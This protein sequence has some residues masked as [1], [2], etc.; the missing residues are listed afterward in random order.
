MSLLPDAWEMLMNSKTRPSVTQSNRATLRSNHNP[1]TTKLMKHT[2]LIKVSLTCL[3]LAVMCGVAQAQV[4]LLGNPGFEQ[5][6][7]GKMTN[8]DFVAPWAN[9]GVNYT[10]T[11]VEPTG[12]HSGTYRAFEM[13]GDDGAYQISPT[14]AALN[15][16]D[17]IVLAWWALG[18]TSGTTNGTGA[19]DPMQIVGIIRATNTSD[20]FAD[21]TSLIITSNGLSNLGWVQ[22]S[23]SYTATPADAGKFPGCFFNTGEVGTNTANVWAGYDDFIMYVLP[24]GSLPI[25]STP[26][27]SQTAPVGSNLTFTVTALNATG[28]RW[29]AGAPGSGVYTNLPNA[30]QY[31]GVTTT[32][33][34][35]T[36]VTTNNNLDIVVVVSNG[37]GSVTS[38]PPANLTVAA[39]IYQEN[40]N[41]PT[42]SDQPIAHVGWRNDI[43]GSFGG[44]DFARAGAGVTYPNMAVYSYCGAAIEAFYGTTATINGGPYF[45]GTVSNHMAFPGV[46]LAVAQNVSFKVDLNT[47]FLGPGTRSFICVQMNL[48]NWFVSTNELL[49]QPTG[50]TFITDAYK[51]NPIASAWNDLTVSGTGSDTVTLAPVIGT[52]ATNNMTGYITGIGIVCQHTAGST[53][54]FDNYTVLGAIPPSILPV[55]SSPPVSTTN[56]TGTTA[57]FSVS[58][59]SNGV[60]SVLTYQ[61]QTNTA[62]GSTTW[63]NVL[64]GGQFSGVNTATLS[65]A[66]V[67]TAA[68]HKDYRVIVT[69]GAG[70]VTSGPPNGPQATLTVV[71]SAPIPVAAATIYPNNAPLFS[72]TTVTNEAGNNNT[73]NFTASF[74]GSQPISYQWQHSPNA[75]GSGA[76]NIPGA[77]SPTYTLSNLQESNTGFYSLKASNTISGATS[78]NTAWVQLVVLPSTNSLIRWSAPVC[79]NGL[80]AAQ[81]LG[82]P[83]AYFSA[84]SFAAATLVTVTN[85]ATIFSFDNTGASAL[86]S[87]QASVWNLAYSGPSTGD[88]NLDTVLGRGV[89]NYSG[90]TITLNNLTVGRLYSV[91]LI[92][93]N[94]VAGASRQGSFSN[95]NDPADV[96]AAFTFG[97]NV[98][99]VG[100]FVATATT[101]AITENLGD[102]HGYISAAIIRALAPPPAIQWSGSNL[103]VSWLYG[104]LLEATNITGP[105]KTNIAT[106]PYTVAPVGPMKFYRVQVP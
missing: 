91:Q 12:P 49:P 63:S 60:A 32:T 88:T 47:G 36:G 24:P 101:Q 100:T 73:L 39:I 86:A 75:D 35:V 106:S 80:T 13:S 53:V 44:R 46:N 57:T 58:A 6:N 10:N 102:G 62:V 11:G 1:Q 98:Y 89:E 66:N 72:S 45:N 43:N 29:Q 33:L 78:T 28:Y 27:A 56:F 68:N 99:V 16:G 22:Y 96:S 59:N 70:S 95:P 20:L 7:F 48:G 9:D 23:L 51:F 67:T 64:N 17:Q 37:S 21:T 97:D 54:Q 5:P 2:K 15:T 74:T 76:V 25:I 52:A 82:L 3:A 77:T 69:D 84:E 26:P 103:Q 104:T 79:V 65:I 8:F 83:G 41:L 71:N 81:I 4:N 94:D 90:A 30:G 34:T 50:T 92:A 61:W 19:T 105:W 18:T 38:A 93:L 87:S 31:S 42:S 14:A 55:I 85:G 40:F